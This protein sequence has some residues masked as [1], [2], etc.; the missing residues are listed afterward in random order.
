MVRS[1]DEF[2]HY[3]GQGTAGMLLESKVEGR[4]DNKTAL[5]TSQ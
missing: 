5:L 1:A 3:S 2:A 4:V